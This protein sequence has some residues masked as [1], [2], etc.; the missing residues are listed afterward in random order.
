MG[1][2]APDEEGAPQVNVGIVGSGIFGAS[3]ALALARRGR[4]VT[5]FDRA[6]EPPADDAAS[7]DRSKALRFEYGAHSALYVPLVDESRQ[8]YR[9]LEQG[10]GAPLYVETGVLALARAWTPDRH[11]RLSYEYLRAAGRPIERLEPAEA[12]RRFPQFAYDGIEA[13][14]WNSE[15]GYVRAAEAVRATIAAAREL[16]VEFRGGMRVAEVDER[17]GAAI[18]ETEDGSAHEFDA[19]VVCAGPW[20]QQLVP[21]D[22][23][24]VRPLRQFVTYYRPPDAAAARFLPPA[25]AVWMHDIV[26]EGW[27]GMP[28]QDGVLKV[29]HHEPGE[30]AEP[31]RERVVRQADRAAS[32]AFVARNLPAIDPTWYAED[33]GCLYAMT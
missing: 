23:V 8:A 7:N 19:V 5:V 4:A 18:V 14:T 17:P 25:F 30:P 33:R 1:A 24:R 10:W 15:G 11:E 28:L 32:R 26:D 20:F 27:Y 29:A 22:V 16:G 2:F 9:E 6:A 21:E 13:V 3:T 12:Q 31:D